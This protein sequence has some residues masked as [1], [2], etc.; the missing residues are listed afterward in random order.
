[1]TD[2][3]APTHPS[4][5]ITPIP[6]PGGARE[7]LLVGGL[8]DPPH[9]AHVEL[10]AFARQRAAAHD[11]WLIFVPATASPLK[12]RGPRA[13]DTDRVAMLQRA[14][15][16]LDWAAIWTDE[17]DRAGPPAAD[18]AATPPE[19]RAPSYWIDTLRRAREALG[20]G[21]AIRFIIGADQ[22]AEFHRWRDPRG[23]LALAR[24]LVLLRPPFSAP[25]E[26]IDAMRSANFWNERD[27]AEWRAAIVENP[28]TPLSAS[29][30]RRSIHSGDLQG[31]E[32]ALQPQVLAYIRER[33]L[34][35]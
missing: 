1:M 34:Y 30:A 12:P 31:A 11:A 29:A 26:L 5:P 17:I 18:N 13:P 19:A 27:L 23:V 33:G 24:P 10:P 2:A 16:G 35:R 3:G 15:D 6:V 32:R 7:V 22:A 8:F 9:R 20:P 21:V 14:I 25:G 4:T 28:L